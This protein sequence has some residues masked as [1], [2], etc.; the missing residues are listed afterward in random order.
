MP[1][2]P[3]CWRAWKVRAGNFE[4]MEEAGQGQT[5]GQRAQE[6][7]PVLTAGGS[8]STSNTRTWLAFSGATAFCHLERDT[9]KALVGIRSGCACG[10]AGRGIIGLG[11]GIHRGKRAAHHAG[12]AEIWGDCRGDRITEYGLISWSWN[13]ELCR[14]KPLFRQFDPASSYYPASRSFL[15]RRS[16]AD[17]QHLTAPCGVQ[18]ALVI[19]ALQVNRIGNADWVT[20]WYEGGYKD[21]RR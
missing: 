10:G 5:S 21:G 12:G 19:S 4:R 18:F 7:E 9:T 17:S 20:V 1:V 15:S 16:G 3:S 11:T 13:V 2:K 6:N 14:W 8:E